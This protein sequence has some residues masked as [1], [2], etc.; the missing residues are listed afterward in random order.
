MG[1]IGAKARICG[2]AGI[3][4]AEGGR[5]REFGTMPDGSVSGGAHPSGSR[6]KID[7]QGHCDDT[8]EPVDAGGHRDGRTPY[9]IVPLHLSCFPCILL[10]MMAIA[11]FPLG[12]VLSALLFLLLV[13]HVFR[14]TSRSILAVAEKVEILNRK[15][16][17]ISIPEYG[18]FRRGRI[19]SILAA[20]AIIENHL[21][22]LLVIRVHANES[23]LF[24]AIDLIEETKSIKT[25]K[26][27]VKDCAE[28]AARICD[29]ARK[30]G[31][32]EIEYLLLGIYENNNEY[33]LQGRK[34]AAGK[35]GN[36]PSRNLR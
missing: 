18:P 22:A 12:L 35:C 33:V 36:G 34:A 28:R 21:Q 7:D 31:L 20:E 24:E 9:G 26:A 2:F 5:R 3:P 30:A 14:R 23:N 25:L 13:I 1:V 8:D 10:I 27:A 29:I 11:L 32:P 4:F 17:E 6:G 16:A 15:M 19:D